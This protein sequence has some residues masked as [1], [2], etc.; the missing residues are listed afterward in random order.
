MEDYNWDGLIE[1]ADYDISALQVLQNTFE[2]FKEEKN[3]DSVYKT[4]RDYIIWGL[5]E[6]KGNLSDDSGNTIGWEP[7]EKAFHLR[8]L[9][10]GVSRETLTHI[11]FPKIDVYLVRTIVSGDLTIINTSN[12]NNIED[13][14]VYFKRLNEEER[15]YTTATSTSINLS[16][17][18]SL[19]SLINA[20]Y[21]LKNALAV[22]NKY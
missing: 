5:S 16:L 18:K 13:K 22:P 3:D 4:I 9:Q 7:F 21:G 1:F 20:L 15:I 17:I 2:V 12:E 19:H 14:I 6:L 8:I 11:N 10:G